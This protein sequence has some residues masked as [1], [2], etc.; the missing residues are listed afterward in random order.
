MNDLPYYYDNLRKDEG[1]RGGGGGTPLCMHDNMYSTFSFAFGFV[2]FAHTTYVH[3]FDTDCCY[4]HV[5][6]F[7][8]NI[9]Y[10]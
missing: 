5:S 9:T 6:W 1:A 10:V 4:I 7:E 3:V 2:S 8:T